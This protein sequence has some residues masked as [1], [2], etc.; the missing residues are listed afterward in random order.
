M[1]QHFS[2]GKKIT[3]AD[4]K[5]I[6]NYVKK[7][8]ISLQEAIELREFDKFDTDKK[9]EFEKE[10]KG[11]KKEKNKKNVITSKENLK[12]IFGIIQTAFKDKTF[13]SKDLHL[14][15]ADKFTNRQTPHALTKLHKEGY[16]ELIEGTSPKTYKIKE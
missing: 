3:P 10:Q 9:T 1:N 8:E 15:V 12:F 2:N 11:I 7:L 5:S 14:L 6:D 16:L 4:W 13:K